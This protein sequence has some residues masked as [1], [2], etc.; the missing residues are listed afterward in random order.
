[1][2]KPGGMA[3]DLFRDIS[4][5]AKPPISKSMMEE[6]PLELLVGAWDSG[7]V[8]DWNHLGESAR[9]PIGG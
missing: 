5:C 9:D 2:F 4:I 6:R 1:M 7:D 3:S 8:Q